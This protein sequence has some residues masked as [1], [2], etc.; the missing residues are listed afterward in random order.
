MAFA[1]SVN[2][3]SSIISNAWG[4]VGN[5]IADAIG[6]SKK[7]RLEA[8]AADAIYAALQPQDGQDGSVPAHPFMAKDQWD[9][10]SWS[11]KT[12]KM[13]GFVK[14]EAIKSALE[15]Q[16]LQRQRA[17]LEQQRLQQLI[18]GGQAEQDNANA[19]QTVFQNAGRQNTTL[20]G[21]ISEMMGAPSAFPGITAQAQGTP[22]VARILQEAS[23][24]RGPGNPLMAQHL[25]NL[26]NAIERS[27]NNDGV[28]AMPQ[29]FNAGGLSGIY[30]KKTG[31]IHTLNQGGNNGLTFEQRIQ[32][33]D[34]SQLGSEKRLLQKALTDPLNS[35]PTAKEALQ[36]QIEALDA[37]LQAGPG[38]VPANNSPRAMPEPGDV[39]NGYRFKGGNP[40]I[41]G[42]WVKQ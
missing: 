19:L 23:A 28:D 42:N 24:Y 38:T 8:K 15:D 22:D 41:Q 1:P 33:M 7:A 11:D 2:F 40:A 12:A 21:T 34:R 10:L 27:Q 31:A 37:R 9:S 30:S 14:A 39:V 26:L 17:A 25:P 16:K 13:G 29:P 3:D 18:A 35:N 5:S 32:L 6:Q 4:N 20:P 36:R